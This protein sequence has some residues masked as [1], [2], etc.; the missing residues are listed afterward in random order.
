MSGQSDFDN[1]HRETCQT[2]TTLYEHYSYNQLFVG[3]A[4]KWINMTFK[5]IFTIGES[6]LPGFESFYQHCHIPIDNI[7]VARLKEYGF[8]GLSCAWSRIN[9]YQGYLNYQQWVRRRF[10]YIPMDVEFLLWLGKSLEAVGA[11]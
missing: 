1:W 2:L 8:P 7:I 3:Q 5:Y 10:E 11:A 4:Q 6:R 9:N